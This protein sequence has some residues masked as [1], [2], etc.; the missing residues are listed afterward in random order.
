MVLKLS[1]LCQGLPQGRT[2]L[3]NDS[4]VGIALE[5][6]THAFVVWT[7]VPCGPEFFI[8][9]T[10]SCHQWQRRGRM[11]HD[12]R[13]PSRTGVMLSFG[14]A[15]RVSVY[16]LANLRNPTKRFV[17]LGQE[18]DGGTPEVRIDDAQ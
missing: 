2:R 7:M 15:L 18:Y 9:C 6:R 3:G 1:G 12:V 14:F 10:R 16:S 13:N 8:E 5:R 4:A 11:G 17:S